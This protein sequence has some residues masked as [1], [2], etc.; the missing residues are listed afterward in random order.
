MSLKCPKLSDLRQVWPFDDIEFPLYPHCLPIDLLLLFTSDIQIYINAGI[1]LQ[2]S[3]SHSA[4]NYPWANRIL[5][6][7]SSSYCLALTL[8][9]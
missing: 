6:A 4:N 5:V 9:D 8:A 7:A 2:L 1:L 3:T